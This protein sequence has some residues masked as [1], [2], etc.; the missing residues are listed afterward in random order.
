MTK[1]GPVLALEHEEWGKHSLKL[2]S[3]VVELRSFVEE[4]LEAKIV[5]G[6]KQIIGLLLRASGAFGKQRLLECSSA[7]LSG[8]SRVLRSWIFDFNCLVIW[9]MPSSLVR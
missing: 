1:L 3:R 6:E 7:K 8:V 9:P 5:S 2:D 4:K